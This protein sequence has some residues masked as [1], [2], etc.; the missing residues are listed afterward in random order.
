MDYQCVLIINLYTVMYMHIL[1][2]FLESY[3]TNNNGVLEIS[4]FPWLYTLVG[5]AMWL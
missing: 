2:T 5:V 4:L 1:H 3:N